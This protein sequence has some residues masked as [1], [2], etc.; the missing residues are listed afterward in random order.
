VRW[1]CEVARGAKQGA[2]LALVVN[3]SFVDGPIHRAMRGALRRFFDALHLVDLG[4]NALL[5]RTKQRD[6]NVFGVRPAVA[7]LLG[8]RRGARD[9]R[10]PGT[11][12]YL[13]L[14][15][16][17]EHKLARLAELRCRD[18]AFERLAVDAPYQRFV[19]T[20]RASA[21]YAS[22][23]SLADAMP[24]HREGVQTNRDSVVVDLDRERLLARLRAFAAGACSAELAPAL[25]ALPHYD[26]E[27]ARAAVRAALARDPDAK[28]GLCVRRLAYR[29]FDQRWFAPIAPLCH[30][31]RPELLAAIDASSF[32]LVS[33][34]KDRGD[35]AWAHFAAAD[36]AIDNCLLST[37]S[38]CRARAF[39]THD[40][41]GRDN[42]APSVARA[43]A[44][45]IGRPLSSA[46]FCRYAL[47]VLATPHYRA[48]HEEAL[49]IDY[50]RIAWPADQ[51][52]FEA[53]CASGA[54][55]VALFCSTL[56]EAEGAAALAQA[57]ARLDLLW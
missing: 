41:Q 11:V 17:L 4:G 18:A 19:P 56:P 6:D 37:R 53:L 48:R 57:A 28:R 33:V 5:A 24:F 8:V 10:R 20:R 45:R 31:P 14:R 38:S 15:G 54:E 23:P 2:V 3:A 40:P 42:L 26:P 9:E 21:E 7:L 12:F 36:S 34:R 52:Q 47:A 43:F 25:A 46:D 35:R 27:R 32:A 30:R 44:E 49:R 13:R 29:R 16:S 22:W 55:L 1:G 50:P 51:A 39:P